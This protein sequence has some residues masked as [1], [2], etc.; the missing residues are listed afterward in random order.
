[1]KKCIQKKLIL[2]YEIYNSQEDLL[3]DENKLCHKARE[4]MKFSY[5]PY[6]N[7]KVGAAI[8]LADGNVIL[9]SN[10]ENVAFGP[11]NCGERSAIFTAGSMGKGNQI[12]K[13][14]VI[15]R[16]AKKIN[17]HDPVSKEVSG[18]PCGV[19]RQVM[20]EYE[21]LCKCEWVIL[22]I[23][24]SDRV[25]RITGVDTLLPLAFTPPSL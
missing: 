20:K 8:Q 21:T 23:Q 18:S 4:A 9:G 25:F 12:R 24:N 6:S 16:T 19:C 2:D 7:F 17:I 15:A 10:Q 1:M 14:A 5:S 3:D 22:I 13:I 11:T